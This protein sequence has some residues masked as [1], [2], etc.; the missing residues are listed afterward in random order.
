MIHL[1]LLDLKIKLNV[2]YI[3][4]ITLIFKITSIGIIDNIVFVLHISVFNLLINGSHTIK[5]ANI[6]PITNRI[7]ANRYSRF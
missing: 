2:L 1:V 6:I 3:S 5:Y 4:Y 7:Y